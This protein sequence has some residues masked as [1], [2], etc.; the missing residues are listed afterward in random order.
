[1][2]KNAFT[3]VELIV[4][5]AIISLLS[6]SWI[7]YMNRFVLWSQIQNELSIVKDSIEDLNFKIKN[8]EFFD[9]SINFSQDHDLYYLYYLNKS[10]QNTNFSFSL[11]DVTKDFTLKVNP[12]NTW[13]WN[14]IL[15]SDDKLLVSKTFDQKNIFSWKFDSYSSYLIN[16]KI[17]DLD[18]YIWINY[19]WESNM[20]NSSWAYIKF[21]GVY[22]D[23]DKTNLL[24]TNFYIKNVNWNIKFF[25]GTS[26]LSQEEVF[27]FFEREGEQRFINLSKY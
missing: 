18:E 4:V 19:F 24:S 3:L 15:Y 17:R 25:N 21:L 16:S 22:N 27:V 14:L 1:M 10:L 7:T 23:Q 9:Y 5:V 26:E 13:F 12:S 6:V 2:K 8:K 20:T 11:D